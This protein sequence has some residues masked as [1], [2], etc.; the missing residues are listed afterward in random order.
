MRHPCQRGYVRTE[1]TFFFSLFP[2]E[3]NNEEEK[4]VSWEKDKPLNCHANGTVSPY[5][6]HSG[7]KQD[8]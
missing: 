8:K 2:R 4:V 5:G 7:K 1:A 6:S 3:T